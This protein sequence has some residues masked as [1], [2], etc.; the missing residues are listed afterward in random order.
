MKNKRLRHN[1]KDRIVH[2]YA[3]LLKKTQRIFYKGH[4]KESKNGQQQLFLRRKKRNFWGS[5]SHIPYIF[6]QRK[7]HFF[8][9]WGALISLW[10]ILFLLLW[11]FLKVRYIYITRQW[12]TINI[13][14][15][16]ATTD[17]LR[18]KNI[19]LLDTLSIANRLQKSQGAIQNIEFQLESFNTLNINIRSYPTVFQSNGYLI[20]W[21]G[22]ILRWENTISSDIPSIQL[23]KDIS[24]L[25]IFEETL[26]ASEIKNIQ[27]LLEAISKNIPGFNT[28]TILYQV[29][30]K[31]LLISN[32][33]G[34]IFIFDI[35]NTDVS[36]QVK[37]LAVFQKESVDITQ[38]KYIYVDVRI[39]GKLFLCPYEEEFNCRE[40]IRKIYGDFI[41]NQVSS[42]L[43]Q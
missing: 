33:I 6:P 29:T 12:Y 23:S 20:L 16:Y 40:N 10:L 11:P 21:N 8:W 18:G 14:Q 30:E 27:I 5:F 9:I 35:W 1:V 7:R 31:E 19:L 25:A 43:Q 26:N 28:E 37:K 32:K 34:T 15:A 4:K 13:E 39:P 2:K 36:E 41:F 3:Q 22:S 38:K 42:Q 24:E 17:Y